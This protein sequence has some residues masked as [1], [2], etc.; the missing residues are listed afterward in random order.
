MKALNGAQIAM[1]AKDQLMELTGLRADTVSSLNKDE[2]GWHVAV[3]MVELKCVPDQ[4]DLLGCYEVDLDGEGTI[5]QYKR[6]RR[7]CR[8]DRMEEE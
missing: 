7:Y 3:E 1:Q 2:Q 4:K 8:E 6:T 5:I